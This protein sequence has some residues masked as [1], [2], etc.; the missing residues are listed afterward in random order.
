MDNTLLRKLPCMRL[1]T[2]LG[3][4]QFFATDENIAYI[5]SHD[6]LFQNN[7][8][9]GLIACINH[10][11]KEV[12]VQR[13]VEIGSYQGESTSL[14]ALYLKPKELFAMDPFVNGYDSND[15]SS[16][17]NFDDVSYNF[18]LRTEQFPCIKH[19]K[20]FSQNVADKF[21]DDSLDFVY[22]DGEHTYEGVL[23]DIKLYLQ[24]V[25]VNGYLGGHDLGKGGVT[26]ALIEMF[27]DVDIY[28]EDSSWL[29]KVTPKLKRL[30]KMHQLPNTRLGQGL[31]R[32]FTTHP[33][34][35][36]ELQTK[37]KSAYLDSIFE[38]LEYIKP[39]NIQTIVE[40]NCYQGETTELFANYLK[41]KTLYVIDAFDKLPSYILGANDINKIRQNFE[42][43][44]KPFD[45][46]RLLPHNPIVVL[47]DLFEDD[48][49]DMLYI[50][51]HDNRT[52]LQTIIEK[53]LPKIKP[54]G[55]ICGI[56][57]GSGDVVQTCLATIGEPNI[58][59]KDSSWIKQVKIKK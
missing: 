9:R 34:D 46:V 45:C 55:Y 28:F 3:E 58:Y 42:F 23:R 30:A 36:L 12:D 16:F 32:Q 51:E 15:D 59:F 14:F 29:V 4:Q 37:H 52:Y 25:K 24:K 47:D 10:V 1:G 6:D 41:P 38:F 19:I 20:D 43:R 7:W 53:A 31:H 35:I 8:L 33:D 27:G 49:I 13:M 17:A 50:N 18:K 21:E 22:I 40:V 39:K 5:L 54:G 26:A 57:W 56:G 11:K 48:S 44:T 2:G